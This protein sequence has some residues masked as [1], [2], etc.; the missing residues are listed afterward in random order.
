MAQQPLVNLGLPIVET[1]QSH[2]GTPHSVGLLQ[3]RDRPVAETCTWQHAALTRD[4]YPCPRWD[5]N[6]QSKQL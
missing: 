5:S 6:P 2:P 1:S 4:K 3:T